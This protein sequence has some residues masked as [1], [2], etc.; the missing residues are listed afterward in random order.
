MARPCRKKAAPALPWLRQFLRRCIGSTSSKVRFVWDESA[1]KAFSECL[2]C[3]STA[4]IL[5]QPNSSKLFIVEVDASNCGVGVVLSQRASD[6]KVHPCTY[7]S[8][9]LTSAERKYEIGSK[10]LFAV[11]L[12]LEEFCFSLS[13]QPGSKNIKPD[14][15][16]RQAFVA[17]C[18]ICSHVKMPWRPPCRFPAPSAC[19]FPAVVS[20]FHPQTNSQVERYNQ[21]LETTLQA[22]CSMNPGSWSSQLL[23]A[24]YAHNS[25]VT[26]SSYSPFQAA[27]AYQQPLFPQQELRAA[28][29]EPAGFVRHTLL[30][31]RQERICLS[32]N[33]CHIPAPEYQ[34]GDKVWLSSQDVPVKGGARKLQPSF[35]SPFPVTGVINPVAVRLGIPSSLRIHPVFHLLN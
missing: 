32:A 30:L 29:S 19:T 24:E 4:P 7:F 17:A 15:L 31:K 26:L 25:L 14:A 27:Y 18:P 28:S 10:E 12:A 8:H 11:K 2:R 16:S 22:L 21:D 6:D 20:R 5:T 9:K 33:R 35:L 3:F 13:Y 23:W 1:A 34:V